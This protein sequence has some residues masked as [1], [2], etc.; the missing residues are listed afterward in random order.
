MKQQKCPKCDKD[1]QIS[2]ESECCPHCFLAVTTPVSIKMS[3]E[4]FKETIVRSVTIDDIDGTPEEFS[5]YPVSV[6]VS[7]VVAG[8]GDAKSIRQIQE[9]AGELA[10]FELKD[11]IAAGGYG[12]IYRSIQKSMDREVAIKILK[13]QHSREAS[14]C[15]N[16]FTEAQ[17]TGRLEHPNIVPVHDVGIMTTED[18]SK[19]D[20][21]FFVMKESKGTS[22]EDVIETKSRKENLN[23]LYRVVDAIGFAHSKNILHCDLKPLNVMIGEFGEVLVIDWGQAIDTSRPE[24]FRPGGSLPYMP[25]EMAKGHRQREKFDHETCEIGP[26]TDVYT[27]GAILFEIVT[28]L[29]PHYNKQTDFKSDTPDQSSGSLSKREI[30]NV[31]FTRAVENHICE[32]SEKHEGDELLDIALRAMRKTEDA[33]TTVEQFKNALA[34]YET[35]K[36]SIELRSR[37]FEHLR[38][39]EQ[40]SSYDTF[41]KAKLGFE[42][43]L[44]LWSENPA[45]EEGLQKTCLGC[46]E[47]ALE[48]QNFDLGLETLA[49]MDNAS[50]L[51][52]QKKLVTG[53]KVRDRR[54]RVIRRLAIG[55]ASAILIGS[56]GVALLWLEVRQKEAL[57]KSGERQLD[58]NEKQLEL[59]E[60]ALVQK[61]SELEEKIKDA[62]EAEKNEQIAIDNKEKA[63]SDRQKAKFEAREALEKA[64]ITRSQA[65]RSESKAKRAEYRTDIIGI[66]KSVAA[67]DF[68]GASKALR[69]KEPSD[70]YEVERLKL[71]SHPKIARIDLGTVERPRQMSLC[72]DRSMFASI[73]KDKFKL[74]TLLNS[75][76]V[77]RSELNVFGTEV[78]AISSTAKLA[79]TARQGKIELYAMASGDNSASPTTELEGGQ[80]D[81]I[82]NLAFG[83]DGKRIVS[84]GQPNAIRKTAQLEH[85]VMCWE[86]NGNEWEPLGPTKFRGQRLTPTNAQFSHNGQRILTLDDST[87]IAI[88]LQRKTGTAKPYFELSA[89]KEGVGHSVFADPSGTKILSGVSGKSASHRL[90]VWSFENPNVVLFQSPDVGSEILRVDFHKNTILAITEDKRSLYWELGDSGLKGIEDKPRVFRGHAKPIG[91]AGILDPTN[92]FITISEDGSEILK[93]NVDKYQKEDFQLGPSIAFSGK[94]ASATTFFEDKQH[95]SI[96]GNDSGLISIHDLSEPERRSVCDLQTGAWTKHIATDDHLFALSDLD[97]LYRYDLQTGELQEIFKQLSAANSTDS[98]GKISSLEISQ[99]GQ[100]AILQRDNGKTEF[101]IWRFGKEPQLIKVI[102]L[103]QPTYS[104]LREKAKQT[105]GHLTISPDGKWIAAAKVSAFLWRSDGRLVGKFGNEG[106][107][108]RR[109]NA[110]Q[111]DS[112]APKLV[113]SYTS[114]SRLKLYDL[115]NPNRQ[116][117]IYKTSGL[118]N[119]ENL[120]NMV[121]MSTVDGV[122][123]VLVRKIFSDQGKKDLGL[124]LLR[125]GSARI[126]PVQSFPQATNGSISAGKALIVSRNSS[127]PI[128]VYDIKSGSQEQR[129]LSMNWIG[130]A[131]PQLPDQQERGR[132]RFNDIRLNRINGDLILGWQ[133]GGERNTVSVDIND[134]TSNL[135]V[136]TN[137]PIQAVGMNS[138]R[139]ITLAD[140]KL[141]LWNLSKEDGNF[142]LSPDKTITGNYK[143]ASVS[144][145]ARKALVIDLE[146]KVSVV[147]F[148]QRQ[149][150]VVDTKP[151]FGSDEKATA[152][153]WSKDGKS[154]AVGYENGEIWVDGRNI[155][156]M[157]SE[158]VREIQFAGLRNEGEAGLNDQQSMVVVGAGGVAFVLRKSNDSWSESARFQHADLDAIVCADITADGMRVVTGSSRRRVTIWDAESYDEPI[159][160]LVGTEPIELTDLEKTRAQAD[161]SSRALL[162]IARLESAVRSVHFVQDDSAVIAIEKKSEDVTLFPTARKRTNIQ[163]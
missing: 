9:G 103:N 24:S 57:V 35:H 47:V 116:P 59:N 21:P 58:L 48:S 12:E 96:T 86:R 30:A 88:V 51:Q 159:D 56:L 131:S 140:T 40:T 97:H 31:L 123:F 155:Q 152:V 100:L 118:P 148:D 124:A 151:I 15:L 55:F 65:A 69:D 122:P 33:I 85:E 8:V 135:V 125:L 113:V 71:L 77:E 18:G 68:D 42:E 109:V 98:S 94:E 17:L 133:F 157:K 26:H 78:G 22:W 93:T 74:F 136:T 156:G 111:F 34:V 95:R 72:W 161:P 120:P 45:A 63:E 5:F 73:H 27:L 66:G 62:Q 154:W 102:N 43:S 79:A 67:G 101:E 4:R 89:S 75:N 150:G 126:T 44:E 163:P 2:G 87:D 32:Y 112:T 142:T 99:N 117:T 76:G 145:D 54:K 29:C 49:G 1:Y 20:R 132:T 107:N 92:E 61:E 52:L 46:A 36:R 3:P 28:G 11:E 6:S 160:N 82:S 144:S 64:S 143:L 60:A 7:P 83:V 19:R 90:V 128:V 13:E 105:I 50:A 115:A 39:A 81:K 114:P 80:S 129:C 134:R 16:L 14:H 149:F 70:V 38:D 104:A 153:A 162:T 10:E 138:D 137:P 139:V 23:I 146:S 141:R 110:V 158:A 53:K 37:A 84:I 119:A 127:C 130:Q 91:Y 147:D 41:Q 106:S 108:E 25:P 121:D